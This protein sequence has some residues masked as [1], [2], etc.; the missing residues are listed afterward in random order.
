MPIVGTMATDSSLRTSSYLR[1]GCNSFDTKRPRSTPMGFWTEADVWDYI[2]LHNLEYADIYNSGLERTGCMF[3]MF[4]LHME[5]GENK[6]FDI[7]R[8]RHP[9][10]YDYCMDK[11]GLR[12]VIQYVNRGGKD[13]TNTTEE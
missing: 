13:H 1:N 4:G 8:Q 6:R 7:M 10:L 9:K 5:K 12:E 11:L 2:H 3:C